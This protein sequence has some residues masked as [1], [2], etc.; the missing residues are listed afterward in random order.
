MQHESSWPGR[1]DRHDVDVDAVA[2]RADGTKASVRLSNLSDGGCH[3]DGA[4]DYRVGERLQIA[5][6]RMGYVRVQVR[7]AMPGCAGAKFL[8]ESDF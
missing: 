7:W 8:I 2:Y 5:M 3:I 6:P 4:A 1:K